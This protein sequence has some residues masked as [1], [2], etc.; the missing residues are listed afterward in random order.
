MA[1]RGMSPWW[2]LSLWSPRWFYR[3]LPSWLPLNPLW[4]VAGHPPSLYV[5]RFTFTGG[6]AAFRRGVHDTALNDTALM[7]SFA[8]VLRRPV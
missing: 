6:A 3:P 2:C 4:G 8:R 5:C 7:A 1:Y